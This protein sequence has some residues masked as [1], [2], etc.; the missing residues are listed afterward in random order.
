M[1]VLTPPPKPGLP[2]LCAFEAW[3]DA[4]RTALSGIATFGSA[5]TLL[6]H[7]ATGVCPQLA[8]HREAASIADNVTT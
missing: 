6:L 5:C 8:L 4:R 1:F 3:G 2:R 7:A